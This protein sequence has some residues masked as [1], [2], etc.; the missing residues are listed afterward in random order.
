MASGNFYSTTYWYTGT[1]TAPEDISEVAVYQYNLTQS[2]AKKH[3]E[4]GRSLFAAQAIIL[5]PSAYFRMNESSGNPQD[6][7]GN[8]ND[9]TSTGGTLTYSQSGPISGE[10][11]L[12]IQFG[13]TSA[14]Q[15]PE[16]VFGAMDGP[17]TIVALLKR[18]DLSSQSYNWIAGNYNGTNG[19]YWGFDGSGYLGLYKVGAGGGL[20][21]SVETFED[22][23]WHLLVV[24]HDGSTTTMW[25]DGA[26][27][28]D[29]GTGSY[30]AL[31]TV[32]NDFAIGAPGSNRSNA[33][34]G[35]ISEFAIYNSILTNSDLDNLYTYLYLGSGIY[36]SAQAL[37]TILAK[38]NKFAQTQADIKRTYRGFAQSRT[39]IKRTYRGYAQARARIKQTYRG[40]AQSQ[41]EIKQIYR[42]YAQSQARIKNTY[43]GYAQ[44]GAWIKTTQLVYSQAQGILLTSATT[45]NE[46]ANA[47]AL[48]YIPNYLMPISDIAENGWLGVVV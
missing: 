30:S 48:I 31:T 45:T 9:T 2:Q 44:A 8:S 16:S 19:W 38:S 41:A 6:S 7:S 3:Y 17:W 4:V 35:T 47:L 37:A 5:S 40:S 29:D 22:T 36:Q 14:A 15:M 46:Y 18:N 43:K 21:W 24:R 11:D 12:A 20:Y 27:L 33:L 34:L 26:D 42:G 25:A 39:R 10:T 13:A 1:G 28:T 32:G 23:N